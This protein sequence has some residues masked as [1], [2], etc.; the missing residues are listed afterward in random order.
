MNYE[1]W[2]AEYLEDASRLKERVVQLR[3]EFHGLR[4]EEAIRLSRRIAVLYDMYLECL[5][6]GRLLTE[7][8][9]VNERK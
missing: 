7:R 8:G 4:D 2:G 5:H 1:K 6:V 3:R 9:K